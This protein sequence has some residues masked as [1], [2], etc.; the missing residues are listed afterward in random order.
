VSVT[1]WDVLLPS[2]M[3]EPYDTVVP[4]SITEVQPSE[5]AHAMVTV[6]ELIDVTVMPD[7]IIPDLKVESLLFTVSDELVAETDRTLK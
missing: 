1:E 2:D 7:I 3:E 6:M 5:F 4:Y